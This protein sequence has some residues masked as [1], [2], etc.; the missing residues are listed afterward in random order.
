MFV[1][2][3][4]HFD[5]NRSSKRTTPDEPSSNSFQECGIFTAWASPTE[6]LNQKTS[7]L[8]PRGALRL[9]ILAS[10]EFPTVGVIWAASFV[11]RSNTMRDG[12][13][14]KTSCGS[15]NYAAPEVISGK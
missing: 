3:L 11:R 4:I 5:R 9:Q 8:M 7:F 14:L 15:P 1:V 10:G 13:F 6:I 12:E 2:V